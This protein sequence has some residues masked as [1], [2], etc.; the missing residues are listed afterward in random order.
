MPDVVAI[1]SLTQESF[2]MGNFGGGGIIKYVKIQ[3]KDPEGKNNFYRFTEIINGIVSN[4]IRIDNDLLR[5]GNTLTQEIVQIRPGIKT[6]DTVIVFLQTIDK[7]VFDYFT[8]LNQISGEGYGGQSASPANPTSNF[9]N[10][11]LG[12]FSA[13]SVRSKSI[14]IK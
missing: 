1:D 3:Y 13:Y 2:N 7:A 9:N 10:G 8:Q 4:A 14:I 5:D 12:Y 6:G 11:A